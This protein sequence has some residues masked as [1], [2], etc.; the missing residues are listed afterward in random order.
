MSVYAGNDTV[1]STGVPIQ[2]NATPGYHYVWSPRMYLNSDTLSNPLAT[3]NNDQV[4]T[5]KFTNEEGCVTYDD[6]KVKVYIGPE[7][8]VPTAFTPNNDGNNDV[9]KVLP[10]GCTLKYFR[11]FN[12]WGQQMFSTVIPSVSW[13]GTANGVAQ[14][15][16]TYVWMLQAQ[17]QKGK[18]M[19]KKGTL[20][21][22]R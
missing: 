12:R 9:L 5:V 20:V 2:L 21:L 22:I 4:F 6:V 18:M 11:I 13:D 15:P 8:Y 10:V 17:D 16:G 3:L 19:M 7:V 14:Q 1:A